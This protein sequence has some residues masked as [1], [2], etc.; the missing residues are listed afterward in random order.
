MFNTE[1]AE[2]LIKVVIHQP[3]Y[4]SWAGYSTKMSF[5]DIFVILDMVQSQKMEL[6]TEIKLE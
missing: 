3:N 2:E 4:L 6:Y 1:E 5:C